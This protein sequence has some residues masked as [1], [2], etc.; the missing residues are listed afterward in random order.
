MIDALAPAT[1]YFLTFFASLPYPVQYFV[2][3]V[4]GLFVITTLVN[5]VFR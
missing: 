4:I 5:L 2:Y 1:N 3:L